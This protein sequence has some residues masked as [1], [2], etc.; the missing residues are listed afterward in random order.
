MEDCDY[1]KFATYY[2]IVESSRTNEKIN[3]LLLRILRKYK[4]KKI[5][6]MTCGTGLQAIF[7]HRHGLDV[8]TSDYSK[9]M[10]AIAKKIYTYTSLVSIFSLIRSTIFLSKTLLI[11]NRHTPFSFFF[12]L[13]LSFTIIIL[14]PG[15][16]NSFAQYLL[17]FDKALA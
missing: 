10:L 13:C 3:P 6:D 7:L 17:V 14:S 1:D 11:S 5:L 12:K 2:D 4:A 16:F 15:I 9:N 8:V